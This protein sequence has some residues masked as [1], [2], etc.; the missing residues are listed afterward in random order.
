MLFDKTGTLTEGTPRVARVVPGEGRAKADILAM[1]AAVESGSTHPLARAVVEAAE[2]RG[3]SFER[4]GDLF[5]ESGTGVRGTVDGKNVEVGKATIS[6]EAA[7]LSPGLEKALG[8]IRE[9]GETPLIVY[10]DGGAAGIISV[11]DHIRS[12]AAES[13]KGLKELSIDTIG[14]LSGD[15]G[16]AVELVGSAVGVTESWSDLKPH[17]KLQKIDEIRNGGSEVIF[18][19]DGINDAPALAASSVGIAMGARGTEVA[20]ETADIALMHDDLSKLPFLFRLSKRMVT[21]IKWNIVFGMSFNLIAVLAGGSG[22]I[23]PI[24]GAVVHNVGSV[25]VVLSSASIAFVFERSR[26]M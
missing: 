1:A 20:L 17:H 4:A 15:H 21:I 22:M 12:T 7:E 2:E 11:T 16:R 8:D 19:G 14:I 24:L 26:G 6:G 10:V 23:S 9:A 5:V 18:V 25:I 3:I 13:V